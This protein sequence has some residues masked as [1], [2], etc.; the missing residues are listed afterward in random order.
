MEEAKTSKNRLSFEKALKAQT[1]QK[2]S[3]YLIA[4]L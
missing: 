1:K 3:S 4:A 2:G